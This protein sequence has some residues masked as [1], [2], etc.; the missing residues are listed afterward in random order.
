MDDDVPTHGVRRRGVA[1]HRLAHFEGL[2]RPAR[3]AV[4][5]RRHQAVEKGAIAG[6]A[7]TPSGL[8]RGRAGLPRVRPRLAGVVGGRGVD[9]RHPRRPA[10]QAARRGDV[11]QDGRSDRIR[12]LVGG[13]RPALPGRKLQDPSAG[14]G[15]GLRAAVESPPCRH[16]LRR[17]A[18]PRRV[19]RLGAGGGV[20][21][22]DVFPPRGVSRS[23][24]ARNT[25]CGPPTIC[26][27]PTRSPASPT[28]RRS[29]R[30]RSRRRT[31]TI[32][33][34]TPSSRAA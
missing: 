11:S 28:S 1:G 10:L 8:P 21:R 6:R 32:A 4:P 7:A 25:L 19:G 34:T 29:A 16:A 5:G 2:E 15:R 23:R 3:H 20:R 17:A 9:A 14:G 18:L 33:P 12:R 13:T 22:R 30:H 27:A 24:R 31:A 26:S